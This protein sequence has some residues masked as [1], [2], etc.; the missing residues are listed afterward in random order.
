MNFEYTSRKSV[1]PGGSRP[2][3]TPAGL[4]IRVAAPEN[5]DDQ[6][7]TGIP[8]REVYFSWMP[9]LRRLESTERRTATGEAAYRPGSSIRF[10]C[11]YTLLAQS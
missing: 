7:Q 1:P 8:A 2:Q 5:A 6:P 9:G 4:P 11:S 3:R 10:T